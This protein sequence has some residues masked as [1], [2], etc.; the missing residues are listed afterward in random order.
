MDYNAY[1]SN[2]APIMLMC[3]MNNLF[4]DILDERVVIFLDDILTYSNKVEE[5]FELLKKVLT[6][7]HKYAFYRNSIRLGI[8]L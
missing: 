7:L 5:H 3:I 6:Y 8:N 2:K 1:G 4:A